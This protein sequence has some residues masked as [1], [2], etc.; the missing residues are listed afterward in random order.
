MNI[1]T[2]VGKQIHTNQRK[3]VFVEKRTELQI[4]KRARDIG[5]KGKLFCFKMF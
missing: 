2:L 3:A 4:F 1:A 5:I